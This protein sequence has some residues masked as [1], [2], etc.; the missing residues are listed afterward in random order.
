MSVHLSNKETKSK[1]VHSFVAK[2]PQ[3]DTHTQT[4]QTYNTQSFL[5]RRLKIKV[6]KTTHRNVL[7]KWQW[8]GIALQVK[9][10]TKN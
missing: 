3:I 9:T 5:R 10:Y 6:T 7:L 8:D 4:R 1:K 2:M